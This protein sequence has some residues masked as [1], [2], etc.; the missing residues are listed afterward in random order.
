[1]ERGASDAAERIEERRRQRRA[2]ALERRR[3]AGHTL[4]GLGVLACSVLALVLLLGS[5]DGIAP[6]K[7]PEGEGVREAVAPR[8]R[9]EPVET[10]EDFDG[11]VPILM[12]HVIAEA[13][14]DAANPGL[15]VP[16]DELRAQVRRLDRLGYNAVT[17]EQLHGA[18]RRGESIPV[19]P[20]VLS[21]DDGTRD[22]YEVAAPILGERGWPGVMN[23][24][25]ESLEQGEMKPRMVREMLAD[26]W[27]L[28]SHTDTH[29]DLTALDEE[30]LER[31]VAGSRRELRERFD[32]PVRFFC[33]P[34]GA[35]D[36]RVLDAVRAAGYRGATTVEPGLAT[37]EQDPMTL[38]RVRVE[39]GDGA[40]GLVE[41]LRAA[42]SRPD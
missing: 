31:E 13:P 2:A 6:E 38:S 24:K 26:G 39:P 18:W 11:P 35:Y 40:R 20:I 27:E 8:A 1:M 36:E 9:P 21:F 41:K 28:A 16:P 7:V 19:N 12:Y 23:L 14:P 5:G 34:A 22:H 30:A 10:V 29:P 25:L 3:R 17:L 42:G 32:V 37:P 4:L 15:F 33:Y